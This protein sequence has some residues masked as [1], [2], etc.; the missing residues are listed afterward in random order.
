[1]TEMTP[2]RKRENARKQTRNHDTTAAYVPHAHECAAGCTHV[3]VHMHAARTA[4]RAGRSGTQVSAVA[5]RRAVGATRDARR[6]NE[7]SERNPRARDRGSERERTR[8]EVF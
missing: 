4:E 8:G 7:R 2:I 6:I 3:H 5:R 1:M